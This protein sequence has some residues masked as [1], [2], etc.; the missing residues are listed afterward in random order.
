MDGETLVR[1]SNTFTVNGITYTLLKK[2]ANTQEVS[3][4]ADVDA[5]YEKVVAFVNKYNEV[6]DFINGKLTEKYDKDYQPLTQ[7]QKEAMS[8]E[9]IKLWEERAKSG[10]LRNDPLLQNI[11]YSLR[12]ALYDP[13]EGVGISFIQLVLQQVR[14]KPRGGLL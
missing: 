8:E 5:V 11:V 2:S 3:L 7:E 6:I 10:L 1:S 12:K 4:K 13:V 9:E 14:G